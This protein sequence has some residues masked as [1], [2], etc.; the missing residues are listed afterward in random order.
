MFLTADPRTGLKIL[1]RI[2]IFIIAAIT[3]ACMVGPIG[4]VKAEPEPTKEIDPAAGPAKPGGKGIV[5]PVILLDVSAINSGDTAWMLMSTSLVLLMT[6]PGLALFMQ[7]LCDEKCALFTDANI[8]LY[9]SDERSVGVRR[10]FT[11]L[12]NRQSLRGRI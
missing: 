12:F 7:D 8:Y 4:S 10:L 5:D 2:F 3:V 1:M 11:C 6:G 9:G